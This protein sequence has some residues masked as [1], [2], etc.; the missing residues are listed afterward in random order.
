MA[1]TAVT[2][3]APTVPG[4]NVELLKNLRPP[5]STIIKMLENAKAPLESVMRNWTLYP[6]AV[7]GVP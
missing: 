6:P 3:S 2:Y 5:V 4:G 7:V 1:I